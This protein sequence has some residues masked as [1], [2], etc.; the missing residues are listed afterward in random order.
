MKMRPT[1]L[2]TALL[3]CVFLISSCTLSEEKK[4]AN[5][6]KGSVSA[7]PEQE[8]PSMQEKVYQAGKSEAHEIYLAAGCFWGTE[9]YFRQIP[10]VM[11]TEVG[12]ANGKTEKTSYHELSQTGHAETLKLSYDRNKLSLAEILERYYRIIDPFSLNK[13]GNDVGTQYRVAIYYNDAADADLIRYSVEVLESRLGKATVLE[14]A[15]LK[16]WV[17]AEEYH[18]DYLVK[19]PG[20]YCHINPALA[21]APLWEN[22]K[23]PSDAELKKQ[24][25]P[26]V[27]R[28]VREKGTDAPFQHSY[29]KLDMPGIYVDV[30]SG[31]PLFSSLDKYDAGCGWP[32]FTKMITTDAAVYREDTSHGMQRIEVE[33]EA[34]GSHLGHVFP[35]APAELGGLRYCINGSSLRFIAKEEMK[36]EGYEAFL[37]FVFESR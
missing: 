16:N 5:T 35:D 21:F 30:V 1:G 12:Y 32:S 7:E 36:K 33:G 13:Q 15:E 27:Y 4:D 26:D 24:L 2:F 6:M 37:P 28:V 19:N 31:R 17:P 3:L 14:V 34:S 10:G 11:E 25:A 9:A 18:Q 22:S 8:D 23:I 29:D 20:G